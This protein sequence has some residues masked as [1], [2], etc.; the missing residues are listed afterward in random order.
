MATVNKRAPRSA[1]KNIE[2][3]AVVSTRFAVLD[4]LDLGHM[5]PIEPRYFFLRS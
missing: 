2:T 3:I 4:L 1:P 5:N